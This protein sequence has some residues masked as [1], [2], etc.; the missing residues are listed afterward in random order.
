MGVRTDTGSLECRGAEAPHKLPRV[1]SS[2][3][4]GGVICS[5]EKSPCPVDGR[6]YDYHGPY[7]QNGGYNLR[8]ASPN[9]Q[10]SLGV[11]SFQ[12]DHAYCLPPSGATELGGGSGISPIPGLQQLET[13][14][15][16]LSGD[17]K[18]VGASEG[19]PVCGQVEHSTNKICE[20]ETRSR[21]SSSGCLSNEMDTPTGICLSPVLSDREVPSKGAKRTVNPSIDNTP[22]AHTALVPQADG[23]GHRPANPTATSPG[24]SDIPGRAATS[25]VRREQVSPGSMENF[26]EGLTAEGISEHSALL[27]QGARRKGTRLAYKYSWG[28][29]VSWC[30]TKKINPSEAPVESVVNYLGELHEGGLKYSTINTYRSAISAQHRGID[31]TPVGKHE[32]VA[33]VMKGIFNDRPPMPRYT[34]TWDV[35]TVLDHIKT[36]GNNNNMEMKWLTYKVTML[37]ALATACR[38]SELRALD[39]TI[40][41]DKGHEII[42]PIKALTKGKRQGNPNLSFNV[43]SYPEDGDLDVLTC[44]RVYLTRTKGWRTTKQQKQQLLLSFIDPHKNVQTCTIAGWLKA[45]MAKAGIDTGVFKGHSTRSAST[46]KAFTQGLSVEEI[47]RQGNWAKANTFF[48]HYNKTDLK[49]SF[50]KCVFK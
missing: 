16:N 34:G 6:Q 8:G 13:L 1:D 28:K 9:N 24:P 19:R 7:Q 35:G 23:A 47:V 10:G 46:S 27:C 48:K 31:K 39:P 44:V 14:S 50:Q 32:L 5:G 20:L 4:C 37:L 21:G 17:R 45:T 49:G 30:D 3:I 29:W 18:S 36:W 41:I 15:S 25:L 38:G 11:L 22:M 33:Q 26:G 40:M 42:F 2:K 43:T 12:T